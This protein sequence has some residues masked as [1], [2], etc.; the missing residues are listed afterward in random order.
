MQQSKNNEPNV[1]LARHA[2]KTL[3]LIVVVVTALVL[4]LFAFQ[5]AQ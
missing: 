5:T 3:V 1:R 2:H 4:A